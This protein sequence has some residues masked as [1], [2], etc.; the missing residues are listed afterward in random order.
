MSQIFKIILAHFLNYEF[1]YIFVF[2]SLIFFIFAA[3]AKNKKIKLVLIILFSVFIAL[4]CSEFI[5]SFYFEKIGIGYKFNLNPQN[6]Q[7]KRVIRKI[8]LRHNGANIELE[9]GAIDDFMSDYKKL[10]EIIYDIKS[11]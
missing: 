8:L 10:S 11:E 2:L 3:Y 6:T 7:K 5:L 4:G 1:L 9:D